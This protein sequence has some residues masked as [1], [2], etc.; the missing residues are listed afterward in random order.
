LLRA[1]ADLREME[2]A[3]E[4]GL[5]V[6]LPDFEAKLTDLCAHHEGAHHGDPAAARARSRGRNVPHH[7]SG[8]AREGLQGS[9]RLPR[10]GIQKWRETQ[11]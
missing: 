9:A 8:E 6:T 7:D 10:E 1:D 11:L 3:R 4:R 2:L 5:V